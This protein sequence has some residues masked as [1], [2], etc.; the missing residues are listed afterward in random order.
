MPNELIH[1]ARMLPLLA[2]CAFA[3][4]CATPEPPAAAPA[5]ATA[6]APIAPPAVEATAAGGADNGLTGTQSTESAGGPMAPAPLAVQVAPYS[7]GQHSGA[8]SGGGP[9]HL[10][11]ASLRMDAGLYRCE[12]N[13][14]VM[15]RRVA[16]DG[17][18]M[19]I[20]WDG[21]DHTLDA[22]QARTGALRYENPKQGLMWLVIV[23]KSML[24]DTRKGQQLAN[25]CKL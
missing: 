13:R 25:E 22:V 6:S 2:A 1:R 7:H 21:K 23:G 4:A 18:S 12:L 24:L 14:R 15:V 17:M 19:V 16:D 20:N 5:A 11:H 3:A 10:G 9:R 8:G